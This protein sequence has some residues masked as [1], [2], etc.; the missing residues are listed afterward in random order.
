LF[1]TF[2]WLFVGVTSFFC[3]SD[4]QPNCP[5][6]DKKGYLLKILLKRI[7]VLLNK[8]LFFLFGISAFKNFQHDFVLIK[9]IILLQYLCIILIKIK[10]LTF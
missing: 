4:G 5:S 2:F 8:E 9:I 1:S 3:L 10:V 7:K 6:E